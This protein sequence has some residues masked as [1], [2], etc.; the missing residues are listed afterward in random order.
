MRIIK[1][2]KEIALYSAFAY[3]SIFLTFCV[4]GRAAFHFECTAILFFLLFFFSLR[5]AWGTKILFRSLLFL[6]FPISLYFSAALDVGPLNT[7]I[8]SSIL[9]T[10]LLEVVGFLEGVKSSVP[11]YLIFYVLFI[12]MFLRAGKN[13]ENISKVRYVTFSVLVFLIF[14]GVPFSKNINPLPDFVKDF[15]SRCFG[16][17]LIVSFNELTFQKKSLNESRGVASS[18]K[19]YKKEKVPR[20]LVLVIGESARK[21]YFSVYGYPLDTTPF[22]KQRASIVLNKYFSP[23]SNTLGSLMN[24]FYLKRGDEINFSENIV[25]IAQKAG[26]EVIWLSNQ[27]NGG[28]K[29]DETLLSLSGAA[30]KKKFLKK[31][32]WDS[33]NTDDLLLLDELKKELKDNE[34]KPRLF[35]IHMIGSHEPVCKRLNDF[36]GSIKI[37]TPLN[38]YIST[39]EKL[40]F[41]L[42]KLYEA[43]QSTGEPFKVLYFSDHG[44]SITKEKIA[45]SPF[46][47]NVYEV[48]FFIFDSSIEQQKKIDKKVSGFNFIDLYASFLGVKAE[49][50]KSTGELTSTVDSMSDFENSYKPLW[51]RDII[52]FSSLKR[53]NALLP[54]VNTTLKEGKNLVLNDRNIKRLEKCKAHIDYSNFSTKTGYL[55]I[56]GWVVSPEIND[57]LFSDSLNSI[58]TGVFIPDRGFFLDNPRERNDVS[59]YFKIRA[60][61]KEGKSNLPFLAG[62]QLSIPTSHFFPNKIREGENYF[63]VVYIKGNLYLCKNLSFKV[64]Q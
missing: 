24:S 58:Q 2:I 25:S 21:D 51:G 31:G 19:I 11:F 1:I 45:H 37:R 10:D 59:E 16:R 57:Y 33:E 9:Q 30:N 46:V 27:G 63:P 20:N 23:S 61:V 4:V 64:K 52:N 17:S 29:V 55:T 43:L 47:Q 54:E 48:P 7:T 34:G 12:A 53:E 50:L 28:T 56:D 5:L 40:D 41:F 32:S 22:I 26:F 6:Y 3:C 18:L 44:L 8:I 42:K 49:G 60:K 62:I 15:N 36:E 38:C 13:K 14:F 35:V 39:L